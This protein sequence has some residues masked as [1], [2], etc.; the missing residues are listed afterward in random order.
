MVNFLRDDIYDED[1]VMQ[2]EAPKVYEPGGTLK[3]IKTRVDMFFD[4][5]NEENPSKKMD[6]VLVR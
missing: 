4:K 1:G 2:E 5:Y 6:L 3:E